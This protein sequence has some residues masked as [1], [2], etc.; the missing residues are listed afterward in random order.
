MGMDER[1][2][3]DLV[4][5]NEDQTDMTSGGGPGDGKTFKSCPMCHSTETDA[6]LSVRKTGNT[7]R[8]GCG[9]DVVIWWEMCI[10]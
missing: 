5:L 2:D 4:K 7:R 10:I 9:E 1:T 3:K 8:R 6:G